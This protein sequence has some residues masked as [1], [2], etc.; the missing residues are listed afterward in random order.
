MLAPERKSFQGK[1]LYSESLIHGK[2]GCDLSAFHNPEGLR[3]GHDES[4][5]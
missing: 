4:V 1:D 5:P 2:I 3:E